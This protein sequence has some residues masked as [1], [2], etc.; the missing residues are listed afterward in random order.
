MKFLQ[1]L[2]LIFG[3]VVCVNAQNSE[4]LFLMSGTIYDLNKAV[5]VATKI[6]AE[7]EN[8]K[9]F[10][11]VSNNEGVY[12]LSLP[13]GKYTIEFQQEGFKLSRFINF[14]NFSLPERRLDVTLEVGR[15]EDCNGAIYGERNDEKDKPK[16]INFSKIHKSSVV[17]LSGIV[18]DQYSAI[19]PKAKIKVVSNNQTFTAETDENGLYKINLSEGIYTIE[20]VASGHKPYKIKKYRIR[21]YQ[22]M[23]LDVALYANP[24]PI[25]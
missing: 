17:N 12:K 13:F 18:T 8:G 4:K 19:I 14:E 23:N 3:L 5:V 24:T 10:N 6:T 7:S 22:P 25:I 20:F 9:K 15:C 2:V 11:T 1:I 21:S 16:E